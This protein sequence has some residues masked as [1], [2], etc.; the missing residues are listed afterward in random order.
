MIQNPLQLEQYTRHLTTET[1]AYGKMP[2]FPGQ[3]ICNN[4]WLY[5][6]YTHNIDSSTMQV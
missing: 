1:Q 6:L 4:L 5:S 2:S 3:A